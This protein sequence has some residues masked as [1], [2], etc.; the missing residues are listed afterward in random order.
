MADDRSNF[1]NRLNEDKYQEMITPQTPYG[2]T[3]NTQA[4]VAQF[5]SPALEGINAMAKFVSGGGVNKLV[6]KI[7]AVKNYKTT[8]ERL[9]QNTKLTRTVENSLTKLDEDLVKI[10]DSSKM[11][12]ENLRSNSRAI[13]YEAS[14]SAKDAT[15]LAFDSAKTNYG[16]V[17]MNVI[18]ESFPLS[19]ASR[20][21]NDI[22]VDGGLKNK[23][24]LD[25]A[26]NAL[27]DLQKRFDGKLVQGGEMRMPDGTKMFTE[28]GVTNP[29]LDS[30]ELKTFKNVVRSAIKNRPD[31]E[32]KFYKNYGEVLEANGMGDLASANEKYAK[33]YDLYEN[34]K[35]V[36]RNNFTQIASGK[37]GRNTQEF[38]DI[39]NAEKPYGSNYAEKAADMYDDFVAKQKEL[40][41]KKITLEDEKNINDKFLK[42]LKSQAKNHSGKMKFY[43][44]LKK[45]AIEAG[46]VV[47]VGG[48]VAKA[49]FLLNSAFSKNDH[50]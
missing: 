31:L 37:I 7:P 3:M 14:K 26:E 38:K 42:Y 2:R 49:G 23:T 17:V 19:D 24:I 21:L 11:L 28:V 15:D 50:P 5:A 13:G 45:K 40:L 20:I 16:N 9:A 33:A 30:S 47:A 32:A 18:G 12:K 1:R 34:V 46:V 44:G 39:L 25:D 29:G 35:Q 41:G 10:Q 36:K 4:T 22:I 27:F 43:E 6:N 8:A 48:A